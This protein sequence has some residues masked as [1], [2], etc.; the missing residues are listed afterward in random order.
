MQTAQIGML[1]KDVRAPRWDEELVMFTARPAK[2]GEIPDE[3]YV[4]DV[5]RGIYPYKP[6]LAKGRVFVMTVGEDREDFWLLDNLNALAELRRFCNEAEINITRV[7]ILI[8]GEAL[9]PGQKTPL[10]LRKNQ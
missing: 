2:E 10:P 4:E 7:S 5:F 3:V 9:H 8:K 1:T 6:R